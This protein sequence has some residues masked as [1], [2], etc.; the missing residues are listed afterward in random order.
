MKTI[1][2][3]NRQPDSANGNSAC[4]QQK[5]WETIGHSSCNAAKA[6]AMKDRDVC[7]LGSCK[8]NADMSRGASVESSRK[9]GPTSELEIKLTGESYHVVGNDIWY[10]KPRKTIPSSMEQ[11]LAVCN[12]T[13]GGLKV[14]RNAA[15]YWAYPDH[16]PERKYQIMAIAKALL[17]NTLICFP[18]GLGK[19]LIAAVVMN[20]FVRWFPKVSTTLMNK[21]N[22]II[23]NI[24]ID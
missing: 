18:T 11:D 19:T 12:T 2:N 24:K 16:V 3:N 17:S 20:N 6:T 7:N 4:M 22:I 1:S 5:K 10:Y 13:S 8:N 9:P 15:R 14:C 23:S 21:Y